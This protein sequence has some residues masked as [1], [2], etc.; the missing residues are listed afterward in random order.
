M[1]TMAMTAATPK[2]IPSIVRN[3]RILCASSSKIPARSASKRPMLLV[4]GECRVARER[5]GRRAGDGGPLGVHDGSGRGWYERDPLPGRQS[6]VD[7]H[8]IFVARPQL[9]RHGAEL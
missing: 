1:E 2:M 3:E 9:Q 6:L 8:P 5:S 7:D 4:S